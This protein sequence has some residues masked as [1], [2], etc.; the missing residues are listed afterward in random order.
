MGQHDFI[1]YH[2]FDALRAA[3]AEADGD[4]DLS[5]RLHA[6]TKLRL[7]Y[8]SDDELWE[9]ARVTAARARKPVELV[10]K[11]LKQAVDQHRATA[12]EWINE[13]RRPI[14]STDRILIIEGE[15]DLRRELT[16]ALSEAGFAVA[17]V[18]DYPEALASLDKFKP[19][20][21]I[22]DEALPSGDGIDACRELHNLGI[23]VIVLGKESEGWPQAVEAG[24][25]F[26]FTYKPS[27][28]ELV[29]R[30]KAILRR[31]KTYSRET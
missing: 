4:V 13:L 18:R 21:A 23:P 7:I 25:D 10:Y 17:D 22:V 8:M 2:L 20:L 31:Y 28:L 12:S 9:L 11:Q 6:E 19:D 30:A 5:R 26:Y 14:A 15:T 16:S 3:L 29:A 24:A 1:S 27:H